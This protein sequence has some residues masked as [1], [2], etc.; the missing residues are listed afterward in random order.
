MTPADVPGAAITIDDLFPW[1]ALVVPAH[2]P[3]ANEEPRPDALA[4]AA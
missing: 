1:L 2:E 4:E 3:D